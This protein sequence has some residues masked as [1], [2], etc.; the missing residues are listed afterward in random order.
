MTDP[1]IGPNTYLGL[2]MFALPVSERGLQELQR[3]EANMAKWWCEGYM[4]GEARAAEL[5]PDDPELL[6][7]ARAAQ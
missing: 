2:R 4:Q 7:Q 6:A 3:I 5:G 1:R